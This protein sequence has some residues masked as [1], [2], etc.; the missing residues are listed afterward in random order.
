MNKPLALSMFLKV[1]H[2]HSVLRL[3][4]AL[5]RSLLVSIDEAGV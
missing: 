2:L 4:T 1:I 3:S 5:I